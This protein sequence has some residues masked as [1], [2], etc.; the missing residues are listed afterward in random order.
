M[1]NNNKEV[2]RSISIAWNK[3]WSLKHILK[4]QFKM[5]HKMEILNK[6]ILPALIYGAQT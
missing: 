6:C 4:G 1:R 2:E 3:I 5:H